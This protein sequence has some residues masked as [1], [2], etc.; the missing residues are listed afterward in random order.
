MP[1]KAT[2]DIAINYSFFKIKDFHKAG[3]L[4]YKTAIYYVEQNDKKKSG[5]SL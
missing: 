1:Y 4:H 2:L 5:M 3:S